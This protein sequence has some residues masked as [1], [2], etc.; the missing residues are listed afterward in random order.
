M[1]V[2]GG[3]GGGEGG[4][5]KKRKR[6]EG[7]QR[8]GEGHQ[9][10][11]TVTSCGPGERIAMNY[12]L[13]EGSPGATGQQSFCCEYLWEKKTNIVQQDTNLPRPSLLH[14]SSHFPTISIRF[15]TSQLFPSFQHFQN[16]PYYP[17]LLAVWK[18][19]VLVCGMTIIST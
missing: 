10:G 3:G 18:R 11:M 4:G 7:G 8:R 16:F 17:I 13:P 1:C 6:E 5:R 12:E 9:E 14:T 15:H 2:C 19:R